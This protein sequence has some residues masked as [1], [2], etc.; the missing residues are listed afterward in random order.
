M[1]LMWLLLPV[2]GCG[3]LG[4]L[5]AVFDRQPLR[6]SKQ[7]ARRLDRNAEFWK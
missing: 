6:V 1:L 7:W 4:V 2:L 5:A 3:A